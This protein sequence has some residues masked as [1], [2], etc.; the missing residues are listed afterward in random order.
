MSSYTKPLPQMQGLTKEFYDFCKQGELRFQRCLHCNSFRHVPRE[1]CA[2]CNSFEWHWVRATGRGKVYSWTIVERA[3][4]PDFMDATPLAP[5][6]IEL[7]EGVRILSNIINVAPHDLMM[8]MPVQVEFVAVTEA[9][10]LP[11]FCAI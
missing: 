3:L 7:E 8:E 1:I 4:H 5:V 11:F 2:E 9:V 10:T 6:I